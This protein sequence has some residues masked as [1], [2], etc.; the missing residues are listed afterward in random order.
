M[1]YTL[2]VFPQGR[3]PIENFRS[4][5]VAL[6]QFVGHLAAMESFENLRP[7]T[8]R[9]A[10][11]R[12]RILAS[13]VNLVSRLGIDAVTM[14]MIAKD[15]G[16]VEK[17]LYNIFGTKDRLIAIAARDRSSDVFALAKAR[18]AD[19]GWL[20]LL[21]FAKAA[22]EVTLEKP[23]L[24][25]SLARLLLDHSELVGLHEVYEQNVGAMIT[26]IAELGLI[27]Q[28]SPFAL[29]VRLIRLDVVSSVVFWSHAE[30]R[31]AELELYLVLKCAQALLP[32]A[33]PAGR[34][35][36]GLAAENAAERM[37]GQ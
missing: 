17:T 14:R 29:L 6:H 35:V 2:A 26:A 24:S 23:V 8:P 10:D 37:A 32:Y 36:F 31:D 3:V 34:A 15:S 16:S 25:Q 20:R 33:T 11:R 27:R 4:R 22:A 7:L 13:A 5:S 19:P 21:A 9:Q 30:I 18:E 12:D 28:N 1:D